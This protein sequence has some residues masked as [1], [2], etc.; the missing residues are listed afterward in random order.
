VASNI[1]FSGLGSG[2]DTGKIVD[3]LVAAEKVPV[4]ALTQR[5]SETSKRL[6]IVGDL[7]TKL[8]ALKNTAKSFDTA[9]GATALT[10]TSSDLTRVKV[11]AGSNASVGVYNFKVDH[12]AQAETT[13]SRV[14]NSHDQVGESGVGSLDISVGT[15]TAVTVSYDG[16]DSLDEI[17]AKI[18]DSGARVQASVLFDGTSYRLNVTSADTGVANAVS[19]AGSG[20]LLGLTDVGAEV[21]GAQDAQVSLNGTTVT[22]PTNSLTDVVTGVT[23]DLLSETPVGGA[24]TQLQVSRDA[25]GLRSKVQGLIDSY[26]SIA[27]AVGMQLVY[28]GDGKTQKGADTLFGDPTVTGLQRELGAIIA[29]EYTHGTG[30]IS[31]G[32]MGIALGRDGQMT[33]DASK[34]DAAVA[35]DPKALT[36]LLVGPNRD[37]LASAMAGLVDRYVGPT[38]GLLIQKQ[39]S[40]TSL[41][42]SYD[43]QIDKITTSAESLG[44]RLRKQFAAM[45]T[46]MARLNSQQ[47]YIT[48]IFA[49]KA[50]L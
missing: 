5:K 1:S 39:K 24:A 40:L 21:V 46:T 22:R 16:Q 13:R 35:K 41:S 30:T 31:T 29:R 32:E 25:A 20:D 45:E 6:S 34:F 7:V 9:S 27:R 37:G 11:T 19:F 23:F 14:F 49:T 26:N 33:L 50:D 15:D 4:N 38:N 47:S 17:A 42:S 44:T 10:A 28:S 12:L 18:N 48:K 2:L 36:S 43:K 3:Q 8:Q